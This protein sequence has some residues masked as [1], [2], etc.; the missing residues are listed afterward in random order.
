MAP[1]LQTASLTA[2]PV[3]AGTDLRAVDP[4]EVVDFSQ[5]ADF[6]PPGAT[7]LPAP[8]HALPTLPGRPPMGRVPRPR[9]GRPAAAP[10]R[11]PPSPPRRRPSRRRSRVR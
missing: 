5:V 8:Q 3:P 1:H 10:A 7:L 4:N 6:L 9:P 11:G 2:V